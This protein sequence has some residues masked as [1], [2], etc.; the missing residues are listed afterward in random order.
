MVD[1]PKKWVR[2]IIKLFYKQRFSSRIILLAFVLIFAGI[3][4]YL[5][6]ALHAQSPYATKEAESSTL[7]NGT[8]VINEPSASNGLYVKFEG[9]TSNSSGYNPA[10]P[11]SETC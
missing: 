5:L 2:Y 10:I 8:S 4:V 6:S 9:A 7:A 3:G 11:F 1:I